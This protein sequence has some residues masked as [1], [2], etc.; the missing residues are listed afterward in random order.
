MEYHIEFFNNIYF[1]H[2]NNINTV[3][4][5]TLYHLKGTLYDLKLEFFFDK[6]GA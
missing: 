4:I 2:I 1:M 3:T 5:G 6:I